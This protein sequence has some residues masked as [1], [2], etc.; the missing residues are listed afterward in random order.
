MPAIARFAMLV[1]M[2]L[3]AAV[4]VLSVV[5]TAPLLAKSSTFW[6]PLPVKIAEVVSEASNIIMIR[7]VLFV[8]LAHIRHPIQNEHRGPRVLSVEMASSPQTLSNF[9]KTLAAFAMLARLP[10]C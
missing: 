3:L 7:F 5:K 10:N 6:E 9:P 1:R 4:P 8:L 2:P